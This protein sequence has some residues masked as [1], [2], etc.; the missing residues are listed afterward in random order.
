[1]VPVGPPVFVL[2]QL[3]QSESNDSFEVFPSKF[4]SRGFIEERR[5]QGRGKEGR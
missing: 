3:V 2:P 5:G 1:M 4:L